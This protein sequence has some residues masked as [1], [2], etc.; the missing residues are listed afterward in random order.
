MVSPTNLGSTKSKIMTGLSNKA[1]FFK[2][3]K[4]F[5]TLSKMNDYA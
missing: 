1:N 5:K 2:S 4:I 3:N